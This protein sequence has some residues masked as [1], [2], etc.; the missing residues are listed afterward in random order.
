MEPK[1][2]KTGSNMALWIVVAILC[3]ALVASVAVN[4]GLLFALMAKGQPVASLTGGGEDEFPVLTERWSYGQ[5]DTKVARIAVEGVI[6]RESQQTLLGPQQDKID[7]ILRQVRA[8]MNDDNVR[9]ILLEVDS[10]GGGITPSDEIYAA[11]MD[12]RDSDEGRRIVVHMR[13]LAASGGYYVAMA[14]DWLMAEP[15]TVVGSIG[16]I[17]Q[18]INIKGLSEKVGIRD[19]TIKSGKNKDLLNPFEDVPPEQVALLQQLIDAM[20]RHFLGIVQDA[21]P[22][23]PEKLAELADGRIFVAKDAIELKLIDE[24]GYFEDAVAKTAELLGKESVRVIR[25][26]HRP[27]FLDFFAAIQSP[28]MSID[29]LVRPGHPQFM[30]LWTP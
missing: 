27:S 2:K 6:M 10:P 13:D 16:V 1:K 11:L 26:E 18:S 29:A 20:Y 19:I 9:A 5:G 14:G 12:F 25:Y 3:L 24:I 21:R 30:Y 4:T 7:L 8:A 23:E 22:I 15:T 28:G 17:M